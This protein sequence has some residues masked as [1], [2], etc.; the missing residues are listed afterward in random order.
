MKIVKGLGISFLILIV[1]FFSAIGIALNFIFTPTKITPVITSVLNENMQ[2]RVHLESVE[3]T[4]FCTFPNL[5]LKLRNGSML[6]LATYIHPADTTIPT[7]SLLAFRECRVTINPIAYFLKKEISIHEI[8]LT[9]PVIHA[10]IDSAGRANWEVMRHE[11]DTAGSSTPGDTSGAPVGLSIDIK[12]VAVQNGKMTFSDRSTNLDLSLQELNFR[13]KGSFHERTSSLSAS[14]SATDIRCMQQKQVL[15]DGLSLGFKADLGFDSGLNRLDVNQASITLNSIDL[16]AS[17]SL[18]EDTLTQT[19]NVD[20]TLG[21]HVKSLKDLLLMIPSGIV[22]PHVSLEAKGEVS[23]EARVKGIYGNDQIPLITGTVLIQDGYARYNQLPGSIDK[24]DVDIGF[25]LDAGKKQPSW[26]EVNKFMFHCGSSQVE[27]TGRITHLLTNPFLRAGLTAR[28]NFYELAEIFPIAE[29]VTLEGTL[30]S[31][32]DAAFRFSDLDQKD[33]GMLALRGEA[34]MNDVKLESSKDTFLFVMN[35]A[36]LHFG[37][38]NNDTA[39]LEQIS[40]LHGLV[41]LNGMQLY[42]QEKLSLSLGQLDLSFTT[43]EPK[44]TMIVAP[45]TASAGIQ[46]LFVNLSDSLIM[47]CGKA[48]A[49]LR[50]VPSLAEPSLGIVHGSFSIDTLAAEALTSVARLENA[51]INV[52][53]QPGQAGKDGWITGGSI[54]FSRL[55]AF[56][57]LFPLNVV[58]DRAMLKFSPGEFFLDNVSATVGSSNVVLS[59]QVHLPSLSATPADKL[60]ASLYLESDLIDLNEL[61]EAMNQGNRYAEELARIEPAQVKLLSVDSV[62]SGE[63]KKESGAKTTA[64]SSFVVP[65][66]LDLTFETRIRKVLFDD[67]VMESIRGRIE[68]KDQSVDLNELSMSNQGATFRTSLL[69]RAPTRDDIYIGLDLD[70]TNIDLGILRDMTPSLDT[71]LPMLN[72]LD[73]KVCFRMAAEAKLDTNLSVILKTLQG[74][75]SL[76]ADS[77]VILDSENF[78]KIAK[79]FYFKNKQRNLIDEISAEILFSDGAVE[80]FPFLLH[81]DAYQVAV[82]GE[83]NL[84]LSFNYH[85]SMLS[86]LRISMDITGTPDK[87]KFDLVKSRYRDLFIP[88]RK[89]VVDSSALLIRKKVRE[90]LIRN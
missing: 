48:E 65:A 67:L 89:G 46:D 14:L 29:G 32:L 86:P 43:S 12:K 20:L 38:E 6:S 26:V 63:S 11:N 39:L 25:L 47:K 42:A 59:G 5:G 35:Q 9:D 30:N 90:E 24:L 22:D 49:K 7:D 88:S 58:L 31:H 54:G 10:F 41:K 75:A 4:F 73:G 34:Q 28:V 55:I 13:L 40:L 52:T 76:Q 53:T 62:P 77:L 45:L 61:A 15:A 19:V 1:L 56:T 27:A 18:V 33:Y 79:M 68:I 74:A 85:V 80:V 2:A 66:D 84:D 51:E 8:R 83:Q 23:I 57:P 82:G 78:G 21:L 3:L 17:G 87:M 36:Y 70:I 60:R 37:R 16:M 64:F 44:D 71:L 50:V 69:Y 72:S 81:A